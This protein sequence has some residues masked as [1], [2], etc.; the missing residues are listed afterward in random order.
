MFWLT[1]SAFFFWLWLGKTPDGVD[2]GGS[3]SPQRLDRRKKEKT[4]RSFSPFG[5]HPTIPIPSQPHLR[6]FLLQLPPPPNP[7]TLRCDCTKQLWMYR[8][9]VDV[10]DQACSSGNLAMEAWFFYILFPPFGSQ[11]SWSFVFLK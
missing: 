2:G 7:T 11:S 8:H 4:P 10:P 1:L 3:H 6:S 5:G 9:L